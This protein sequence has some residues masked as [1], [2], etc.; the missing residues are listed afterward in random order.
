MSPTDQWLSCAE[1][2]MPPLEGAAGVAERLLLLLHYGIDWEAGWVGK[3]RRTYWSQILPSRVIAATYRTDQLRGWWQM[4]TEQLDA[5]PRRREERQEIV[6]LLAA[7]SLPVLE[8][9]RG[10]A[11]ALVLRT[12]ITSELVREKRGAAA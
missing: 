7:E 4:V 5:S 9:L 2:V 11:E 12:Q 3:H 10:Q 1:D 8:C 6:S